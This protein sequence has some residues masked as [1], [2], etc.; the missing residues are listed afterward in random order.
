M[1][2]GLDLAIHRGERIGLIDSTGSG[3]STLVDLLM[4]LWCPVAAGC[5][6]M[7]QGLHD[8]PP[9]PSAWRAGGRRWSCAPE[10]LSGG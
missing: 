8:T 3:M 9:M 1:L 5:L 4:G 10:H 2:Q 6:W 7:G